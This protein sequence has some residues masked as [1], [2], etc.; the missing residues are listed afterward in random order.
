MTPFSWTPFGFALSILSLA[1]SSWRGRS[2][3]EGAHMACVTVAPSPKITGKETPMPPDTTANWV[4]AGAAILTALVAAIYTIGTFMLW[5]TTRDA[6]KL[7]FLRALCD[8]G[9]GTGGISRLIASMGHG[10][11]TGM[12]DYQ[13]QRTLKRLLKSVFPKECDEMLAILAERPRPTGAAD[14]PEEPR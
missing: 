8:A 3:V 11:A 10:D 2:Q 5:R 13:Q 14:E 1:I 12:R 6:F 7:T 9:V 4:T